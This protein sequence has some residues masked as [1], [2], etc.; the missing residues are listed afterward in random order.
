MFEEWTHKGN[1]FIKEV[2]NEMEIEDNRSTL[3]IIKA[4]LHSLR[5]R[6]TAFEAKDLVAQLPMLLK[7]VW[8][9]G[10]IPGKIPDKSIKKKEDLFE[11]VLYS[12]EIVPL[13]DL[14]NVEDAKKAVIAIFSVLK[15][16]LSQGEID[17]IATQF[18]ED[19]KVLWL[20][21]K[22]YL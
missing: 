2:S 12:S 1:E 21:P 13:K 10:W 3:R 16:H 19:I 14:E 5:D 18:P 4:V 8:C 11:R 22:V 6:L 9:D 20:Q 17:D 7:A 15:R